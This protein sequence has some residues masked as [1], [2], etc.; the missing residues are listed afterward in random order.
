MTTF[1][2]KSVDFCGDLYVCITIIIT[3]I[4]Y[5]RF[6]TNLKHWVILNLMNDEKSVWETWAVFRHLN[7]IKTNNNYV[8]HLLI[9]PKWL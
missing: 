8:L 4:I 2:P 9:H 7:N 6:D 5:K 3:I 1:F